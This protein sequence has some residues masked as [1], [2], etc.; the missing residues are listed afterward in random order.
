MKRDFSGATSLCSVR[1]VYIEV[2]RFIHFVESIVLKCRILRFDFDTWLFH[3][4]GFE[5]G[6]LL[7]LI[8]SWIDKAYTDK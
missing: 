3:V 6:E 1:A 2:I 5:N 4:D 7:N 8:I